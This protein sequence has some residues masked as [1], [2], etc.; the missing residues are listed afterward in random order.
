MCNMSKVCVIIRAI[1]IAMVMIILV[2]AADIDGFN[3]IDPNNKYLPQDKRP[4]FR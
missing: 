1:A 4:E 3:I 2:P